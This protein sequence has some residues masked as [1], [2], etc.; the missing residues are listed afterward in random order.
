MDEIGGA[1]FL[2]DMQIQENNDEDDGER[3]RVM[4][5]WGGLRPTCMRL[6]QLTP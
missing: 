2:K 3:G 4:R 1:F 6:R 5:G